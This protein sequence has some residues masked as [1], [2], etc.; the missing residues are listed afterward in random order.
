MRFVPTR[1]DG[2]VLVELERL[3][4]DRGFFARTWCEQE[5]REHGLATRFVQ[6]SVSYNHRRGTLRGMHYQLAPFEE[7]KLV[8]CSRGAIFDVVIDLRSDSPTRYRWVGFELN[9]EN[10]RM[11]Y[12]PDG[13]AHGFITLNDRTEVSYQI[14]EFYHPEAAAGVHW[15]DPVFGIEWPIKP[16]VVSPRDASFPLIGE[17]GR[18]T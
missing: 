6:S 14:S 17:T 8:R 2:V 7:R 13:C 15:D 11:L 12:I 5:A 1:I 16:S 10:G 18:D 9:D 3:S 4:D